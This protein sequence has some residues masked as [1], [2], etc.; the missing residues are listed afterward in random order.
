MTLKIE[1]I[2]VILNSMKVLAITPLQ[3]G[4]IATCACVGILLFSGLYYLLF[5]KRYTKKHFREYDYKMVNKITYD[6]D[7]YLINNFL[8]R[9]D[10]NDVANVD[11][12]LFGDKYIYVISDFYY[13]GDLVGQSK[14][15]SL[16]LQSKTG[17]R[18]YT[19]NPLMLTDRIINRLTSLTGIDRSLFIGVDL[20]NDECHIGV[21]CQDNDMFLIQRKKLKQLVKTIE[22][23]EVGNINAQE[24]QNAVLAFDK[25]NRR[26]RHAKN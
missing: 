9:I 16:V 3:I 5:H 7:F 12:I 20:I 2:F 10:G 19:D 6:Y 24:L 14:D 11:H 25:L 15:S 21:E 17:K 1:V 23:R 13:E 8:F 22:A 4:F 26:K 18:F